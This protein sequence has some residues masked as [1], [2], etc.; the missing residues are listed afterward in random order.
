M[1]MN[2]DD[3]FIHFFIIQNFIVEPLLLTPDIA[4]VYNSNQ[5]YQ[6]CFINFMPFFNPRLRPTIYRSMTSCHKKQIGK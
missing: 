6:N 5:K 2:N 3:K 1:L 4:G